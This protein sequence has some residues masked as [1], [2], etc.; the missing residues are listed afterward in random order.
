MASDGVGC[1]DIVYLPDS[2]D[3]Q[4]SVE[5]NLAAALTRY[6][7]AAAVTPDIGDD[8]LQVVADIYRAAARVHDQNPDSSWEQLGLDHAGARDLSSRLAA[9]IESLGHTMS[10]TKATVFVEACCRVGR[11]LL[12]HLERVCSLQADLDNAAVE[13][14]VVRNAWPQ[15]DVEALGSRLNELVSQWKEFRPS[16]K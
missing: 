11:D 8:F 7:M 9:V 1:R 2:L 10:E 3:T 15:K 14:T 13:A 12:F 6:K 16:F 5:I 4:N